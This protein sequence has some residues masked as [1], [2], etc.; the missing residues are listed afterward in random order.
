MLDAEGIDLNG[1]HCVVLG[2]SN[3]VGRPMSEL[4]LRR[5]GTVTVCHSRSVDVPAIVRTA[6]VLICAVGMPQMV[7]KDWIKPGELSAGLCVSPRVS[8]ALRER[9]Q[10]R[11]VAESAAGTVVG[12]IHL[13]SCQNKDGLVFAA[14]TAMP[15]FP[16]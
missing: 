12:G 4:L 10:L 9:P 13:V 6:D 14:A 7:K 2:R 3:I 5:N 1:K 15:A 16:R 11:T 8:V